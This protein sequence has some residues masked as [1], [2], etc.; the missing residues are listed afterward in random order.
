MSK[1]KDEKATCRQNMDDFFETI[2]GFKPKKRGAGYELLV[3]AVIKI[4]NNALEVKH[5]V[6]KKGQ[7]SDD[8]YQIDGYIQDKMTSFFVE[9]KDNTE[10]NKKTGRAD[11]QKLAGALNNLDIEAGILASATGF[12]KPTIQ[13]SESTRINPNAKCID[14][15][16]IRPIK[17]EDTKG[18]ILSICVNLSVIHMD[19]ENIKTQLIFNDESKTQFENRMLEKGIMDGQYTIKIDE[20][21]DINGQHKIYIS[22]ILNTE[23]IS[24]AVNNVSTGEWIPNE[25]TYAQI[26]DELIQI[27]RMLY[28]VP[29]L[30][31]NIP[32][33]VKIEEKPIL[34]II[35]QDGEIDKII[36]ER[37]LKGVKFNKEDGSINYIGI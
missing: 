29:F 31:S 8:K 27:E 35:S 12:T 11:I 32:N 15:F 21:Y 10:K 23:N 20:F 33:F 3:N 25:P 16:L 17:K 36:T 37:Q 6:I 18:R 14:L 2:F 19:E 22:E 28:Q 34:K 5:D 24:P 9:A 30:V 1:N 4:L 26:S 7:F 13:Y